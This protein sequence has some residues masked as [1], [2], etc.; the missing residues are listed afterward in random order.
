[1][2]KVTTVQK[3]VIDIKAVAMKLKNKVIKQVHSLLLCKRKFH[4]YHLTMHR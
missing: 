2:V 4:N 3:K 1:M